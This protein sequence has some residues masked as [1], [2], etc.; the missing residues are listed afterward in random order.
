TNPERPEVYSGPTEGTWADSFSGAQAIR[1]GYPGTLAPGESVSLSYTAN[2]LNS[3]TSGA[4][5]CN[6]LAVKAVGIDTVSEPSPVCAVVQEADLAASGPDTL[7][8]QQGRPTVVP[9]VFENL[10]G[11]AEAPAKVTIEIP[12]G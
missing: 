9:F 2:V 11:T 10:G 1:M 7:D 5:A 8:A 4:L 6:S 12:S 3:P